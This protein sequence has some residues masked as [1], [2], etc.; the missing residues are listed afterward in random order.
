[1]KKI[2]VP[3]VTQQKQ[4]RLAT[5]TLQVQSLASLGGLRIWC[6]CELWCRLQMRLGSAVALAVVQA[7]D[8]SSDSTPSLGTSI[9]CGCGPRKN[10]IQLQKKYKEQNKPK[11]SYGKKLINIK[12]KSVNQETRKLV[13]PICKSKNWLM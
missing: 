3:I 2:G 9:C 6:R 7:S 12:T 10:F 11:K 13:D 5:M 4:I 1:M 8:C